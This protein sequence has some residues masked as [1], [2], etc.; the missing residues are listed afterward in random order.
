MMLYHRRSWV[1]L[2]A[3]ARYGLLRGRPYTKLGAAVGHVESP[4]TRAFVGREVRHL[5]DGQFAR[6][7]VR[8]V[9][10]H[11]DRKVAPG[12]AHAVGDRAGWFLLVD[13]IRS[14][15]SS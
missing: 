2:A 3:W 12:L 1:A 7:Q 9:L 8:P 4:G 13:G 10:S 6:L 15:Q 11:W 14:P 5:L